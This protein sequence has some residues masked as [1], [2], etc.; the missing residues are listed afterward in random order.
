MQ[1]TEQV[2]Q[3][4]RQG[5]KCQKNTMKSEHNIKAA[6]CPL[7]SSESFDYVGSRAAL[8]IFEGFE[9]TCCILYAPAPK[10]SNQNMKT[11]EAKVQNE[12][13]A[14]DFQRS[15]ESIIP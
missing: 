1:N 13:E 11:V 4:K 5:W 8:T 15:M 12:S 9:G 14:K 3:Q 6:R 2:A 10:I 7:S